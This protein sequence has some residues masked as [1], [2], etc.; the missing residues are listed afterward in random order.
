MLPPDMTARRLITLF[1]PLVVGLLARPVVAQQVDVVRGRI[2][3]AEGNAIEGA[4]ITVTTLSGN[5]SVR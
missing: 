4:Q 3:S 2:S 1:L 5:V